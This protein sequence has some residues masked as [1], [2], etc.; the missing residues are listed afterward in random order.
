MHHLAAHCCFS[1]GGK[2]GASGNPERAVDPS[3][4]DLRIGKIV[5]A[6]KVSRQ[7]NKTKQTKLATATVI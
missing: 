5:S 2:G 6:K 7:K 4:L 1:E 3:R